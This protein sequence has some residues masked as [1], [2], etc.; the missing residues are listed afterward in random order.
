MDNNG[1]S[2]IQ[3]R[4]ELPD[5]RRLLKI[6]L[7]EESDIRSGKA[8]EFGYDCRD[9]LKMRGT[10]GPFPASGDTGDRDHGLKTV[11]IHGGGVRSEDHID[12]LCPAQSLIMPKPARIS[13][14][15]FFWAELGRVYED[16][17]NH[18][19]APQPRRPDQSPMAGM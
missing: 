11:R 2:D 15:I 1:A 16:T 5:K 14:E 6:F 10:S 8:Q 12:A 19:I 9:P 18:R 3:V 13:G 17:D 7:T 4:N